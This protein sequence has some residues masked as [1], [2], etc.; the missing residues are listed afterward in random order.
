M[1]EKNKFG[2]AEKKFLE[3]SGQYGR[4][5]PGQIARYYAALSEIQ[6]KQ[7][8]DAE[9]NLT[10]MDSTGDESLAGLAKFQLAGVYDLEGKAPQAVRLYKQLSDKPT[11]FVPKPL[12]LLTLADHYRKTDPAQAAKLYNQVKLEY[13]DAA[14]EADQGL[15]LLNAKS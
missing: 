8:G 6:L 9:K 11:V 10:Q 12:V 14:E 2:D 1:D 7:Y 3:A 15:E 4:T 13:P 5:R